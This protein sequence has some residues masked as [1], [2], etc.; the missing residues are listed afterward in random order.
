M[1]VGAWLLFYLRCLLWLQLSDFTLFQP[2]VLCSLAGIV[3]SQPDENGD[4]IP[5]IIVDSIVATVN[6]AVGELRECD[7][8]LFSVLPSGASAAAAVPA[9][10]SVDHDEDTRH[11]AKR[12]EAVFNF[13]KKRTPWED[14]AWSSCDDAAIAA[15]TTRV[16]PVLSWVDPK[17]RPCQP[18]IVFASFVNRTPNLGGLA[19]TCEIFRAETLVVHDLAVK[20]C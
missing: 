2:D 14:I 6:D 10:A 16:S 5:D 18:L 4:L 17:G 8:G 15:L 3:R 20:V 7:V 12:I 13:Q 11:A 19:R 9:S 1:A